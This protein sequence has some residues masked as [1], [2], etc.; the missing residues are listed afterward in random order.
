M[1][2]TEK[3]IGLQR[4]GQPAAAP[5]G[6]GFLSIQPAAA[7]DDGVGEQGLGVPVLF[8]D[9]FSAEHR[10]LFGAL[11]LITRDPHEAEEIGQ[12]AFVRILERWDRVGS[13]ADPTAYLYRVA[14]N[15]FRSRYRRARVAARRMVPGSF[16]DEISEVDDRDAV[17]RMLG[18]LIPQQRA[19]LVLTTMLGYSSN[20]AGELL[21]V[22]A[23]TVRVLATRARVHLRKQQ[24][25]EGAHK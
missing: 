14:M 2:A 24:A 6:V 25:E 23:S 12:E 17:A 20:E 10:R 9:L 1:S 19:A 21:G 11:C 18:Q 16:R 8:E 13:M 15:V 3:E 5:G 7:M 22:R 4:V